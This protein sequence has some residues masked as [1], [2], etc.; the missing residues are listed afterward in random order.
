MGIR[1]MDGFNT[2]MRRDRLDALMRTAKTFVGTDFT[3]E[4][5]VTA[6]AGVMAVSPDDF[7]MVGA[8]QKYDNM[9]INVGHG[10]RG[11]NWSVATAKLLSEVMVGGSRTTIDPQI[12]SPSRFGV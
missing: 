7:P 3:E 12:T 8:L 10:F 5:D 2:I 4:H 11:T 1:D 9:F 6:W